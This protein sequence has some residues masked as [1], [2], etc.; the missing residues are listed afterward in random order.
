MKATAAS[1][2]LPQDKTLHSWFTSHVWQ[3]LK[4]RTVQAVRTRDKSKRSVSV[5]DIVLYFKPSRKS[6]LPFKHARV[7]DIRENVAILSNGEK[8]HLK[9]CVPLPLYEHEFGAA[10][11][12]TTFVGALVRVHYED[13]HPAVYTGRILK[14]EGSRWLVEWDRVESDA[15]TRTW[16]NEW[17]TA[18]TAHIVGHG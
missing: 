15:D 2:N 17:I 10:A 1:L 3:Q 6:C 11:Y 16:A 18:N 13:P 4:D 12:D 9:N 8:S 5:N 7:T 14:D